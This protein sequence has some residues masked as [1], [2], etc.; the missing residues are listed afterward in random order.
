MNLDWKDVENDKTIAYEILSEYG[1]VGLSLYSKLKDVYL[2]MITRSGAFLPKIIEVYNT[3]VEGVSKN[4][5]FSFIQH[6]PS[7]GTIREI[8]HKNLFNSKDILPMRIIL[9][10]Y[11]DYYTKYD[12]PLYE[13]K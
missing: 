10:I 13:V 4:D 2:G 1:H 3:Q 7:L 9:D 11:E 12:H 6:L 8:L 5:I